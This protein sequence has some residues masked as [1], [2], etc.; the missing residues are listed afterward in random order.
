VDSAR[1]LE[2]LRA[3]R[4]LY[5]RLLELGSLTEIDPFLQE[6]LALVVDVTGAHSGYLELRDPAEEDADSGWFLS[7]GFSTSE[8]DDVRTYVS[9]GIIAEA[10]ATEQTIDTPS[11]LLD[12]RFRERR[13]VQAQRID[14]VL[15]IP[16]GKHPPLGALYLQGRD[17]AGAF[18]ME[19]RQRAET[20]A[21]HLRPLTDALLLRLKPHAVPDPTAPL[22]AS[23]RVDGIVGRSPALATLLRDVAAVSPLDVSVLLTG[24]SGTGKSLI[25]RAIHEN[26]PR[27]GHPF[28]EVNCAALPEGLIESELFG[29][30]PGGHSTATRRIQGK[31][32]AA[33]SGTLFLDEVGELTLA[34][35]AKLLQLL[36][37]KLYYPL[38]ASEPRR[39]D[40][41]LLAASNA[42]LDAAVAAGS[43]R[44]DL[45]YRLQVL[46]IRVPGLAE[47]RSD[48]RALAQLFCASAAARHGL[49]ALEIS[50]SALHALENAEWPGHVRQLGHT[51]EAALIRAAA[52]AASRIERRHV[53]PERASAG[54]DEEAPLSY[55]DQ[56]R[57]FQASLLRDALDETGWNVSETA[58]RIDLARS[59]V[60]KL[61]G[62]FG[63]KRG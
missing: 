9:S 31:V 63:L 55:Q 27:A 32:A 30:L 18:T 40:V 50:R 62:A 61:I 58:R 2:R 33:E 4:D 24:E 57:R 51:V 19:D 48:I 29:A 13:S 15:C 35:Q 16:I 54:S 28:V 1:E 39:A 23:L 43:F 20:F 45:F 34:S 14:A 12:S 53:F 37:S 6:A 3:E 11:A 21:H 17:E 10:F 38:G 5:L 52:E 7:H 42:D 22:R 25:A 44:E 47:R 8:T 49:P 26:G 36:Q 56:T 46:P 41:R 59:H 60:N